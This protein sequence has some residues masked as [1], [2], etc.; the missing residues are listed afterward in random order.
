MVPCPGVSCCR[1]K[2][3]PDVCFGYCEKES[4]SKQRQAIQTGICQNWF[5]QIGICRGGKCSSY[6]IFLGIKFNQSLKFQLLNF[7]YKYLFFLEKQCNS[8][9]CQNSGICTE[10][11]PDNYKCS[12]TA[13][14]T[15][16][17]CEI[18]N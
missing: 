18:G 2:G 3:V 4:S 10:D 8:S 15:G 9:P 5:E 16:N 11:G 13:G 17:D 14:F 1:E 6:P 12:C 7:F